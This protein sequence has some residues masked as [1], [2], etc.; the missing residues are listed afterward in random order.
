MNNSILE[1][2]FLQH[3]YIADKNT[4]ETILCEC[5]NNSKKM[6]NISGGKFSLIKEQSNGQSDVKAANTGYELDF[7]MMISESLK[8]FQSRT[9]PIIQEIAPGVKSISKPP[10][11]KKKV[12]LIWNCC[13][14]MSEKRLQEL[15]NQK[16]M[17]GKA[18]TH[19][20]D[21]V[22]NQNKNILLFIPVYFTTV[23]KNISFEEQY[24]NV[25]N[26]ISSSTQFIYEF[27]N[28]HCTG[29]DTFLVY[30][31]NIPQNKE[32]SFIICKYESEGLKFIDKVRM[33]SLKSTISLA[34]DN[35]IF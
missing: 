29:Y 23:N 9:A 32:F 27:R 12:I 2:S 21:K 11:L 16:D 10:Q 33:F 3:F 35:E 7:K 1:Y 24:E 25:F 15:R 6:L 34:I 4:Y 17:E 19:F 18:V 26:E 8:E 30:I 28:K 22:I 5:L 20:F 14:N 31:V 13:R